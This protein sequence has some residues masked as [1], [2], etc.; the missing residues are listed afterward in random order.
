LIINHSQTKRYTLDITL[1]AS[2]ILSVDPIRCDIIT[3]FRLFGFNLTH[4]FQGMKA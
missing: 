2:L 3:K 4:Y 1:T